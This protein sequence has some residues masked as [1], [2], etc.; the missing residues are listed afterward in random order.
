MEKRRLVLY[1]DYFADPL[2]TAD[3]GK[4]GAM[5]ALEDLPL[6]DHLRSE[7]RAWAAVFDALAAVCDW[8]SRSAREQWN[9]E[10]ERLRDLVAEALG[11]GYSV[12]YLPYGE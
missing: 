10:G 8:P 5:I 7:L 9:H 11:Q 6:P 1:A 3:R 2:W 12:S 4:P